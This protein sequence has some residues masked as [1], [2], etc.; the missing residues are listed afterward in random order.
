MTNPETVE[1]TL[2]CARAAFVASASAA[3]ARVW[4]ALHASGAAL[5]GPS[6]RNRSA[7][8]NQESPEISLRL[9]AKA[10]GSGRACH[11]E[12]YRSRRV[13]IAWFC[14]CPWAGSQLG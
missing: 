6:R 4:A 8:K 14:G 2:A 9:G 11:I 5:V 7:T 10:R 3:R 13:T 12:R 1:R